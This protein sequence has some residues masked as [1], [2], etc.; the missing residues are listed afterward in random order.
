MLLR[1]LPVCVLVVL[2]S[3]TFPAG[4]SASPASPDSSHAFQPSNARPLAG[5]VIRTVD[6]PVSDMHGGMRDDIHYYAPIDGGLVYFRTGGVSIVQQ[7]TR[8]TPCHDEHAS[9]APHSCAMKL[10]TSR[11]DV[12]RSDLAAPGADAASRPEL[13]AAGRI[14]YRGH[15][16]GADLVCAIDAGRLVWTVVGADG[17]ML[18]LP[19][20]VTGGVL[21]GSTLQTPM[22]D[23]SIIAGD[24]AAAVRASRF[25][26]AL[27]TTGSPSGSLASPQAAGG[28]HAVLGAGTPFVRW[29]TYLGGEGDEF[30]N[31]TAILQ[32]GAIIATGWTQSLL[33]PVSPGAAQTTRADTTD[34]FVA[35]FAADG[36]REWITY[37]G[38]RGVDVA[39]E[40]AVDAAGRI[41]IVGSTTSD[42]L[43][44]TGA[45]MLLGGTDAF[46]ARFNP[47]G[48][49]IGS[50]YFGG[51]L[52][53]EGQAI[54]FTRSG[55]LVVVGHTVS[56]DMPI[57]FNLLQNVKNLGIDLFLASFTWNGTR[58]WSSY[59]GGTREDWPHAVQEDPEGNLVIAGH[60]ESG[61]FPVTSGAFQGNFEGV[62]DGF[63]LK[64]TP[65]GRRIFATF[66]GGWDWDDA[67]DVKTDTSGVIIVAGGTGSRNFPVTP[68]AWQT[69]LV[70]TNTDAFV[71]TFDT[72]GAR[73]WST[74]FGG[75]RRD[76]ANNIAVMQSGS[77]FITGVTDSPNLPVTSGALQSTLAG[78]VRNDAFL[79]KFSRGGHPDYCSYYGGTQSEN[80]EEFRGLATVASDR[81]GTVVFG[82]WTG[83]SDFPTSPGALQA[84]AQGAVDGF[85]TVLG[86]TVAPQIIAVAEGPT[87]FC[88]GDSVRITAPLGYAYYEWSDGRRDPSI[89]VRSPGLYS[90]FVIDT[91]DC[92]GTS[93]IVAVDVFPLPAPRIA[94]LGDTVLCAGD[95]VT[96]DA[97]AGYA[98]QLWSTGDTT[99]TIRVGVSMDATVEVID[100][101]GCRGVSPPLRVVVHPRPATTITASGPLT[102]CDGGSVV[103]DAGAG[104]ASQRWSTGETTR[105]ITVRTPGSYGVVVTNGFGCSFN[106]APVAVT[107]HA[108][109]P[110][111][112][113][114]S[115]PMTFCEGDSVVLSAPAGP[116]TYRWTTGQTTRAITL[117]GS[118]AGLAVTVSDANACDSTSAP[119]SVIMN[120]VPRPA[121]TASRP[122]SFCEGDSVVLDAGGGYA[123]YL[124][125]TG[126]M[127]RTI[128]VRQNATVYVTVE[129]ATGCSGRSSDMT[130]VVHP[131]PKPVVIPAG[132]VALCDG[133]SV[134]LR[135]PAGFI[136]Y[137]WSTGAVTQDITVRVGGLYNVTVEDA[138]GCTWTSSDVPVIVHPLPAVPLISQIRDTLVSTPEASYQWYLD[139]MPLAGATARYLLFPRSG[140]Y[141]VV[142]TNT[143]GCSR[144][145]APLPVT[146]ALA[147]V[148]IPDLVAAPGQR[149]TVPLE[150]V[151]SEGLAVSGAR[152]FTATVRVAKS[153]F[154]PEAP[155]TVWTDLGTARSIVLTGVWPDTVGTLATFDGV[156]MLGDVERIPLEIVSFAWL[157]GAVRVTTHDGSLQLLTCREGG[158]RLFDDTGVQGIRGA[159]PNP[160]NAMT[161]LTWSV[162]E[163]AP[164]RVAV[165]DALGREVAVLHDRHTEPGTYTSVFDATALPSGVYHVVLVAGAG[166][167]TTRILL[168]K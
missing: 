11:V 55:D 116:Y 124:W 117:R 83:S 141:T 105:T 113:T 20:S 56:T 35:R 134:M 37:F 40:L 166:V 72:S 46:V 68:G 57:T 73:R 26:T 98:R 159:A 110:A 137:A 108:L 96:L 25:A 53:D 86:C 5:T 34:A 77:F 145:S 147:L 153:I 115:G 81:F 87:S 130:I 132:P 89:V 91:N 62:R 38:G 65:A 50:W 54:T 114:A 14:V 93:N 109:P 67:Y 125:S 129:F 19:P 135:A 36:T 16:A 139:G 131:D 42:D 150:L 146:I 10:D 58:I 140:T 101:N 49:L 121:I 52:D 21:V 75:D 69:S 7:R 160:F 136:R 165:L 112:I 161:V 162:I 76:L 148:R 18:D 29:S 142:V 103:L 120:P 82:G 28:A 31:A 79:A 64:L 143:E 94:A 66:I 59:Y 151:S 13:D 32:D 43:P 119:V 163:R 156:A 154:M 84:T 22:G 123:R 27:V 111:Q 1:T 51:S 133:D 95:S 47:D 149:V 88:T 158:V 45:S 74:Y 122:T 3:A 70:G 152:S 102:F 126:E 167:S 24:T 4:A 138:S 85:L 41:A 9:N 104:F 39:R 23:V 17:R 6:R 12:W 63:L 30:V 127:T 118:V 90:V 78:G 80:T 107:V 164:A 155:L 157:E 71:M 2:W 100:A 8:S 92:G 106:A 97:G 168:M 15:V 33:F 99:R 128:V 44:R 60:T 144:S 61:G 48:S